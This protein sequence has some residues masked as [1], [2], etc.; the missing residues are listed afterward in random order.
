MK[1]IRLLSFVLVC[2][3]LCS[4][5][6]STTVFATPVLDGE[7]NTNG[8]NY[9][10]EEEQKKSLLVNNKK[11][12]QADITNINYDIERVI[13]ESL[14]DVTMRSSEYLYNL[15]DSSDYIY[16]EFEEGGYA[17]I[18]KQTF[19]LL[20]YSYSGTLEYPTTEDMK[21]YGGPGLYF[22]KVD[23]E[24]I[25]IKSGLPI[26][27]SEDT[28]AEYAQSVRNN[29]YQLSRSAREDIQVEFDYSVDAEAHIVQNSTEFE[30]STTN[31]GDIP[32]LD[33]NPYI[34]NLQI[35][36]GTYIPNFW[37]FLSDPQHGTNSSGTCGAVAAQLLLSYHN[38][39]SDRR[40]IANE[41][42][43]GSSSS[44]ERHLHPN[45]CEDP[46][47]MTS[48]TLGS[49]GTRE[50]G[51]DDSNS[52]FAMVVDAVPASAT[53]SQVK[54]GINTM[55]INRNNLLTN[56]ISYTLGSKAGEY[57]SG[58]WAAVDTSGIVDEIDAGRPVIILMQKSLG[59]S[60]HYIVA[61][62]YQDYTYP[63][64]TNTYSGFVTHFGW[65]SNYL[66]VWV[67]SAWC[68]SY[69]TLK[70]NHTHTYTINAGAIGDTGGVEYKCSVCGHRTDEVLKIT[71]SNRYTERVIDVLP[72]HY[73]EYK[74]TFSTSGNRVI[75]TFGAYTLDHDGY[76]ELFDSNGNR[77][78]Y[79]DD[80]GYRLN[81]LLT[82]NFAANTE[83]TIRISFYD[84]EEQS[85][86][87][88]L[89][90]VKTYSYDRYEDIYDLVDYTMGLTWSFAQNNV[91]LLTYEYSTTRELTMNVTS[92][93]DTYLY[94]IDP[95]STELIQRAS[96][97]SPNTTKSLPCL[98]NDDH[99]GLLDS[100]ITKTFDANVPYLVIVSAYN[101]S[102]A[103]SVGEF[104]VDFE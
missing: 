73:K 98:Y 21:Y 38:F 68:Y 67:N 88:K 62:G 75:Q 49:R 4:A 83:Y 101:P 48:K 5:V 80:G 33:D 37:Y 78:D 15:D 56:D 25:D 46:M 18:L 16:V 6:F 32:T 23:D 2:A 99:D 81:S 69:I 86:E 17:V 90:I 28:A 70:I 29:F 97:T 42:L 96:Y 103:T 9:E 51:S 65:G 11:S 19:E 57:I 36:D 44:T 94:I 50:D 8:E 47:S 13:D 41:N 60:N 34:K 92:E 14:G 89:A 24:F 84:P 55:L 31:I 61:Y 66:N 7:N 58:A 85:G 104:Y 91:K 54:N 10:L 3:I 30:M 102:L 27:I 43:N 20:E 63:G 76:I 95:R 26:E 35:S 74:L 79:D 12:S 45:Y 40:I 64:T 87:I 52:Y 59:G 77:L 39:Y 71:A 53:T 1:K 93:V 82:Y 100:Q 22:S 72:N